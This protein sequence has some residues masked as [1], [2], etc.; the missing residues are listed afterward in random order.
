MELFVVKVPRGTPNSTAIVDGAFHVKHT[1]VRRFHFCPSI[2]PRGSSNSPEA[3]I[4]PFHVKRAID[5][6][7]FSGLAGVPRGTSV[8]KVRQT[9]FACSTW[10]TNEVRRP[11]DFG[12]LN[13]S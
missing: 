5:R 7:P 11:A 3:A 13:S 6:H 4:S 12:K 2:V 10:N 1:R 8:G 9:R